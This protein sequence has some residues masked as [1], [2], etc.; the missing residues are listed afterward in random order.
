M[1]STSEDVVEDEVASV[2]HNDDVTNMG[3]GAVAPETDDMYE[4]EGGKYFIQVY[5]ELYTLVI[6]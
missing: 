6:I 1:N 5:V 2:D 3:K 4:F